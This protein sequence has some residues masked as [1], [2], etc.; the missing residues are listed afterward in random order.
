M[1]WVGFGGH[2]SCQVPP[3]LT[4]VPTGTMGRQTQYSEDL[5][6]P[7]DASPVEAKAG[8]RRD[9]SSI[10]EVVKHLRGG[11]ASGVDEVHPEFLKVWMVQ[12]L[13]C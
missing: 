5:L 12:C 2:S 1:C 13:L 4:V 8:D 7:T 11:W 9:D 6:K 3:D 10:T